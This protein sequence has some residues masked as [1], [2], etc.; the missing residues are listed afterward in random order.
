MVEFENYSTKKRYELGIFMPPHRIMQVAYS[1][2]VFGTWVCAYKCTS[3]CTYV[4]M[5]VILLDSS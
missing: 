3:F 5:Y 1:F 4:R 2:S